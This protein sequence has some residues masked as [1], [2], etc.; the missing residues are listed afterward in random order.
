[1]HRSAS[2][3][4][5][6]ITCKVR[7]PY[8]SCPAPM[9]GWF[10]VAGEDFPEKIES[11]DEEWKHESYML[12]G[13]VKTRNATNLEIVS[14]LLS[15]NGTRILEGD[16][17]WCS[18]VWNWVETTNYS[19]VL[20]ATRS[21]EHFHHNFS[22]LEYVTLVRLTWTKKNAMN[23]NPSPLIFVHPGN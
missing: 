4:D 17:T 12:I 2:L 10:P 13:V 19:F 16:Q 9:D 15:L 18:N 14:A 22:T 11:W 5:F 1:M 23:K 20:K 3:D 8:V 21:Q 6:E 7:Q